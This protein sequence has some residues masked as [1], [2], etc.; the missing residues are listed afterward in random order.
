[1]FSWFNFYQ[2]FSFLNL[3][4]EFHFEKDKPKTQD[5]IGF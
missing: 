1:M 2:F 3:I 4:A 5:L